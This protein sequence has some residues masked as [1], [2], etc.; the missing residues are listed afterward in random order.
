MLI[1]SEYG[2]V[3]RP[4][5]ARL[6]PA[7]LTV[8]ATALPGV[9]SGAGGLHWFESPALLAM[10]GIAFAAAAGLLACH[11]ALLSAARSAPLPASTLPAALI[12]GALPVLSTAALLVPLAITSYAALRL[13]RFRFAALAGMGGIGAAFA[14]LPLHSPALRVAGSLAMLAAAA[15]QMR[16]DAQPAENDNDNDRDA[17]VLTFWSLPEAPL[18]ATQ[19][20]R[21]SSPALGE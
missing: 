17:P 19:P 2:A 14:A 21:T 18:R 1:R 13:P 6:A 4:I 15:L 16:R 20:V 12:A 10:L 3:T 8:A 11:L 9:A 5:P 7:L